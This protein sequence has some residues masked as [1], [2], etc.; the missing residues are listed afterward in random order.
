LERV[1]NKS[2]DQ[3]QMENI[4][5]NLKANSAGGFT[6]EDGGDDGQTNNQANFEQKPD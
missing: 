1:Q 6:P 2:D 5:L 3:L 4:K